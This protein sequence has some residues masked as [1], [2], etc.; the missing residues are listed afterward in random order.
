M[1]LAT[2][3]FVNTIRCRVEEEVSFG[4][5]RGGVSIGLGREVAALAVHTDVRDLG[6]RVR[7]LRSR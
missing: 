3:G 7:Q 6:V 2:V 4:V 1:R 5:N